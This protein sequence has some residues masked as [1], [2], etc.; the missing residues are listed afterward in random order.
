MV[1]PFQEVPPAHLLHV[2][3]GRFEYV[4]ATDAYLAPK[5]FPGREP[6]AQAAASGLWRAAKPPINWDDGGNDAKRTT[7]LCSG[8]TFSEPAENLAKAGKFNS[9]DQLRKVR[10]GNSPG[11]CGV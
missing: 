10:A 3:W 1:I 7:A 2:R 6:W 5:Y 4:G 11:C 8:T 9:T